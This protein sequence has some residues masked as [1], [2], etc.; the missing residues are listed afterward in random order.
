MA[1]DLASITN[2]QR[3]RAP[4]ILLLGTSGCG[5]SEFASGANKPIMLPVKYEEGIDALKV[6]TFPVVTKFEN[7][8]D[9]IATLYEGDHDYETFV[10]DSASTFA[11]IVDAQAI[12]DEGVESKSVLGGGFGHQF[13]TP[14]L[15]WR[16]LMDGLDALRNE[17]NM[18]T[19][20]IG[21][22]TVRASRTPGTESFDQWSF[23][24][25]KK[26][27]DPLVRW[28]DCTL[29]MGRKTAVKKAKGGF[30]K[31]EKMGIDTTGGQRF[32]FT[33]DTPT[34]PGKCRGYFGDLPEE[35][36]LPRYNAWDTFMEEVSKAADAQ[37]E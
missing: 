5:K 33:Q 16:K 30:G 25:D 27:G 37:S 32:L 22:V 34:H 18:T 13:D 10:L 36:A 12:A 31:E 28:S 7:A 35:I 21:H 6:K 29:F 15:L 19:I 4:R 14:L 3:M 1:F 20:I 24:I 9:A 26:I 11:P 8:M 23:D 2:A 17:R